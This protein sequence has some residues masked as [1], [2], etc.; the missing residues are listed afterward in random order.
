MDKNLLLHPA[1]AVAAGSISLLRKT[2]R[3]FADGYSSMLRSPNKKAHG[4]DSILELASLVAGEYDVGSGIVTWHTTVNHFPGLAGLSNTISIR[5]HFQYY[6]E[7]DAELANEALDRAIRD[8][9]R[10]ETEVHFAPPTNVSL[11]HRLTFIPLF[12]IDGTATKVLCLLQDI[13]ETRTVAHDRGRH[14][15]TTGRIAENTQDVLFRVSL[16]D[17]TYEHISQAVQKITGYP[18]LAWYRNPY[19]LLDII[20]PAWLTKFKRIFRSFFLNPG[21]DEFTFPILHKQGDIRWIH[22]R[23]SIIRDEHG[24]IL[25]IEGIASDITERKQEERGRN[26]LIRE[27]Q[28]A[29][30]EVKVLSGLLPICS[31]CKKVRDDRGYWKQIEAYI[32]EHSELL[33]THGLC[34]DCLSHHYPEYFPARSVAHHDSKS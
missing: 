3:H 25:A 33:F 26:Q 5:E 11:R 24:E 2:G 22:L 18:P 17:G 10:T 14:Y 29:L 16:P 23:T 12:D 13:S 19:L 34:P 20:Q 9:V 27:L 4:M 6:S 15:T 28:K 7:P 21:S 1:Q 32:S 31:F 8:N 30:A